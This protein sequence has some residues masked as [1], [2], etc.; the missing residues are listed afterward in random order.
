MNATSRQQNEGKFAILSQKISEN[1]LSPQTMLQLKN[2]MI[3]IEQ[4]NFRY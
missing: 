3:A 4:N 2:I 1:G